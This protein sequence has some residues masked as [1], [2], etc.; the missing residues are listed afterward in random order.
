MM[1]ARVPS[2][3]NSGKISF[4]FGE[5][6]SGLMSLPARSAKVETFA[7]ETEQ[8]TGKRPQNKG[9]TSKQSTIPKRNQLVPKQTNTKLPPPPQI[10]QDAVNK[11]N[12]NAAANA[13]VIRELI[14]KMNSCR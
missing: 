2:C 9:N 1:S 12:A 14:N 11:C 13:K 10:S 6:G 5:A 4:S 7:S 3:Q 8:T